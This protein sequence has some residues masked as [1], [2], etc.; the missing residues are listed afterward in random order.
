MTF[1]C[2]PIYYCPSPTTREVMA[3]LLSRALDL[4][5]ATRDYSPTT[6]PALTRTAINRIAAA[7]VTGGCATALLPGRHGHPGQMA[8]FL[9]PV[10]PAFP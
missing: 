7:G 8:A 6:R 2:T 3:G 1:G 9:S 5:P 10:V 4:P